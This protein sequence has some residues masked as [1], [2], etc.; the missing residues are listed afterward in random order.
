[1]GDL[2]GLS[3]QSLRRRMR[4]SQ[5]CRSSQTSQA[6]RAITMMAV[7]PNGPRRTEAGDV[8]VTGGRS[9]AEKAW[10]ALTST[11]GSPPV[12][13]RSS[14]EASRRSRRSGR[15]LGRKRDGGSRFDRIEEHR[16]DAPGRRR[17]AGSESTPYRYSLLIGSAFQR[18][19]H[20]HPFRDA[21]KDE[22]RRRR[23][24]EIHARRRMTGCLT[25]TPKRGRNANHQAVFCDGGSNPLCATP[26][27][28]FWLNGGECSLHPLGRT[29]SQVF[30]F[31]ISAR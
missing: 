5:V 28:E 6:S 17:R 10:K 31:A 22:T 1:M 16:A 25:M 8:S 23:F 2:W 24:R 27:S 19:T 9:A 18:S 30:A 21:S 11:R 29:A 20:L 13:P 4:P 12:H 15:R 7:Q 3:P 14:L 26:R